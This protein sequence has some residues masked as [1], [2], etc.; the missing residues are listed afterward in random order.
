VQVPA[1]NPAAPGCFAL[2][3]SAA[4]TGQKNRPPGRAARFSN[5]GKHQVELVLYKPLKK[6]PGA[7]H[8]IH[9]LPV[10]ATA[11]YFVCGARV[12]HIFYRATQH[13]QTSVKLFALNN[14]G[15]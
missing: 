12:P 5:T 11:G 6:L 9:T 13:F 2:Q 8:L 1:E 3:S 10:I 15:T 14:A 7:Q 4:L